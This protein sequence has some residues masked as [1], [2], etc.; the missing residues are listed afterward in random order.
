MAY[1]PMLQRNANG[2]AQNR[3]ALASIRGREPP[4]GTDHAASDGT[5][6]RMSQSLARAHRAD[7][8]HATWRGR[9][10]RDTPIANVELTR[11]EP[12]VGD[13][14]REEVGDCEGRP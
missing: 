12:L 11:S 14:R 4:H 6:S 9:E 8:S 2:R 7:V 1:A 10:L 13:I 5:M 3:L